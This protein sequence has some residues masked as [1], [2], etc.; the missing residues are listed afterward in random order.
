MA[1]IK[2]SLSY[3]LLGTFLLLSSTLLPTLTCSDSSHELQTAQIARRSL[4]GTPA[5]VI[6]QYLAPHNLIRAQLGLR[7]L[8]WS[9]ELAS[10]AESW[11]NQ[12]RRD[13]ALIHSNSNYGENI[14]WG[15]GKNWQPSDA[16]AAWAAEKQYYDPQRNQCLERD[17]LHYTQMVWRQSLRVGCAKVICGRGD[18]YITCD[19]DPH[20]NVIGQRP[21]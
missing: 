12:R 14:F 5:N 9:D 16:V 19:Y 10:F 13:C 1:T 20:G 8:S 7:P 21:F 11:G 4:G 18:T 6:Q 3:G 15:S 17:C 2:G